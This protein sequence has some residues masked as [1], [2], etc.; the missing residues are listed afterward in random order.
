[1][2]ARSPLEASAA[3]VSLLAAACLLLPSTRNGSVPMSAANLAINL[4][5]CLPLHRQTALSS[6]AA[7]LLRILHATGFITCRGGQVAM[8]TA[9]SIPV[10]SYGRFAGAVNLGLLVGVFGHEQLVLRYINQMVSIVTGMTWSCV[11]LL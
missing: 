9:R 10:M 4:K 8:A 11:P 5:L 6:T 1:M 2:F 7:A 3:E